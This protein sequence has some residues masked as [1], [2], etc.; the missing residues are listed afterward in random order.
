MIRLKKT[1]RNIMIIM[2]LFFILLRSVGL[3]L[4]PMGAHR[5]SE[6]SIHYGPSTVI[7]IEDFPGGKHILGKYDKWVSANTVKKS[8]LLFWRFGSQVTGIENDLNKGINLTYELSEEDYLY[9]GIIND[10]RIEKI[11][12]LL[13]NGE[14]LTQ[15][16]FHE[17]MFVFTG[18]GPNDKFPYI[19][20]VKGYD[21]E[22]NLIFEEKYYLYGG[23]DN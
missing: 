22:R 6:K 1:L 2:V 16:K 14:V 13:D 3:Y 9:Y 7:H 21:L 15:T 11:E 17:N 18:S 12:L 10:G 20:A 8:H 5:A 4:T 23:H 19:E